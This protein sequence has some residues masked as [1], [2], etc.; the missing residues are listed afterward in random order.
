MKHLLIILFLL[1]LS[2]ILFGQSKERGVFFSNQEN[3]K[4][5][6]IPSESTDEV[7]YAGEI[8]NGQPNGHGKATYP[9]GSTYEGE[10]KDG[11]YHGQGKFNSD[12]I[13]KPDNVYVGEFK[14]GLMDGQ[15]TYTWFDKRK[16]VG[17]FRRGKPWNI[18]QFNIKGKIVK[19]WLNGEIILGFLFSRKENGELGWFEK[20]VE[21]TDEVKYAGEIDNGQPN[22]HGKATYPDGSTYEGEWKDGEYHGQGKFNSDNIGK[23]DNVY[24]GEFKDGLMDGQ[25][26]YTWSNGEKYVGEWENNKKHGQGTLTLPSG[27]KYEGN[28]NNGIW[29]GKRYDGEWKG[30]QNNGKA[31]I[32][33]EY[34]NKIEGKFNYLNILFNIL[35]NQYFIIGL[36]GIIILVYG[37]KKNKS[38]KDI[39]INLSLIVFSTIVSFLFIEYFLGIYWGIQYSNFDKR[40]KFEFYLDQKKNNLDTILFYSPVSQYKDEDFQLLPLAGISYYNTILDNENGYYAHYNSDRYGFNNPDILWD[41]KLIDTVI[42]GD[43]L[44]HGCCVKRN[45]NVATNL[46]NLTKRSVLNLGI[47]GISSLTELAILREYTKGKK[48]NNIVWVFYGGNDFIELKGELNTKILRS[49]LLNNTFSQ[50]LIKKQNIIDNMHKKYFDLHVKKVIE[51]DQAKKLVLKNTISLEKSKK[52]YA[53]YK[54]YEFFL[55]RHLLNESL[56]LFN[57]KYVNKIGYLPDE[58]GNRNFDLYTSF[59]KIVDS[60]LNYS[61]NISANLYFV[62]VPHICFL[63][64]NIDC[65]DHT[66]EHLNLLDEYYMVNKIINSKNIPLID[67]TKIMHNDTL[68]YNNY[69]AFRFNIVKHYNEIGY[70]LLAKTIFDAINKKE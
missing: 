5:G 19:K 2:S 33:D 42:I 31:N 41:N 29:K 51:G 67:M 26:T 50:N 60:I 39:F 21:S 55:L 37:H 32:S 34:S 40:T 13:G 62:Y 47:G 15:G 11:E 45:S 66:N 8:D 56:R 22:G 28:W 16:R 70:K 17:E 44:I 49:Y 59:K 20:M 30:E 46:S 23:P 6:L 38:Y 68:H 54:I 14:D 53:H 43:S 63:S 52:W 64:E 48:I 27:E 1:L 36:I 57:Y 4:W 65:F 7:K 3:R 24:V 18:T 61:N 69:Y 10:W 58:S 9:D 35:F 25:G 12:N